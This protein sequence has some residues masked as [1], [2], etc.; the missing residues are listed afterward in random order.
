VLLITFGK[1]I[2]KATLLAAYDAAGHFIAA[3]G[4]CGG[5]VDFS[6]VEKAEIT[7]EDVRLISY[8][9]AAFPPGMPRVF[10]APSP[11]VYG[12]SRMYQII[13]E[14]L[15]S[16][17]HVVHTLEEAYDLLG[18]ESPDFKAIDANGPT[19]RAGTT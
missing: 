8:R 19:P 1:T 13:R 10:V 9:P 6:A 17:L 14:D 18:L 3:E 2:T 11:N 16:D 4:P 7:A 15:A 12:M 5:I